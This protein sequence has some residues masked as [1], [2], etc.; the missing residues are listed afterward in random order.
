[1]PNGG[2]QYPGGYILERENYGG[3][4]LGLTFANLEPPIYT[5]I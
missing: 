5:Y 4:W 3:H 2:I 1:M